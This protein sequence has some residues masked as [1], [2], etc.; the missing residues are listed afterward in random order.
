MNTIDVAPPVEVTSATFDEVVLASETPVLVDFWA[1][2][3]GPC[4]MLEPILRDVA[5]EFAGALRVVK[6]D[7]DNEFDLVA[8]AGVMGFPTLHLYR[9]GE[10]VASILGVRSKA[11]LVD[12]IRDAL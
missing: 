2:G 11:R 7:G 1:R 4:R 6:V 8:A 5:A 3:C 12:D 10:L 9:G